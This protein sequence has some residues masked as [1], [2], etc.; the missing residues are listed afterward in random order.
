MGPGFDFVRIALATLIFYMHGQWLAGSQAIDPIANMDAMG[1]GVAQAGSV[2]R[3]F[4]WQKPVHDQLVPMFF[5]VSGFL[6]TGS[7][8]RL[9]KVSTF[10]A[11]RILRIIPA[12][13]TEVTLSALVLGP[14]LTSFSL[15]AYYSDHNFFAYFLNIV[16]EPHFYLPGLFTGNPVSIVNVNLWTLPGE[17]YCYA[18]TMVGMLTTIVYRPGWA[19]AFLICVTPVLILSNWLAD[20]GSPGVYLSFLQL[21]YYFLMGVVF[22]HWRQRIPINLPLF[23]GAVVISYLIVSLGA[24][25]IF[26]APVFV[27]YTILFVGMLEVPRLPLLQ[28]GDYSYGIYLYGFP[29]CQ[30]LI[31]VLPVL[32]GHHKLLFL[33]AY[34]VTLLFAVASWHFIEKPALKLKRVMSRRA[35]PIDPSNRMAEIA[36]TN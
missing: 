16:G 13:F 17:F 31:A 28:R 7:A 9:R 15:S 19:T 35:K 23:I 11:F 12:L 6:V 20:I 22:Y 1:H 18:I 27:C 10:L 21:I 3:H 29:I 8:I 2:A 32:H 4:D 26:I 24:H 36:A 5:A 30:A 14:L 25:V 33:G 34:P